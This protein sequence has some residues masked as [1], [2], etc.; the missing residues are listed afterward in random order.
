MSAD[1]D[2]QIRFRLDEQQADRARHRPDDPAFRPI[3][4]ALARHSATA[5]STYDAFVNYVTQAERS[6]VD[7]FPLYKWTKA[8]IEDPAKKAKHSLSFA[9]Y[10]N[11]D[12]VYDKARADA[13]EA[14]LAPL[15]AQGLIVSLSK[16]DT[17]PDN[18]PQ[19]PSHLR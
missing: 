17:N 12:E 19:A 5:I 16:H 9:V 11:G 3:A 2:Y 4:E 1:W 7:A 10:V 13:L 18:N 6:S 8:T 14:D 15:V